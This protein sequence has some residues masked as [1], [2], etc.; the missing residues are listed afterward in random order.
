MNNHQ[1]KLIYKKFL[2]GVCTDEEIDMLFDHFG[3]VNEHDLKQLI[4]QELELNDGDLVCTQDEADQLTN[5]YS[6]IKNITHPDKGFFNTIS[7]YRSFSYQLSIAAVLLV[8]LSIGFWFYKAGKNE[9]N[10]KI[11]AKNITNDVAPGGNKAFL[12]LGNG[13]RISLEQ[14]ASGQIATEDGI[15]ISKTSGG[16]IVYTALAMEP[17]NAQ[18]VSF[19]TIET[20]NGG[21]YQVVL[22]DGTRVWLNAASSLVY[23]T[24]FSGNERVVELKGEG[25]F[26]V[27]KNKKL[28]FKVKSSNQEIEV[29]GTHF[30]VNG[31]LHEEGIK[32]TLLEGSVKVSSKPDNHSKVLLP[33]QQSLVN[34][35][36]IVIKDVEAQDAAAWKDGLFQFNQA[37][38]KSVMREL[39]RWYDVTV[40]YEGN[41]KSQ[42]FGG[43]IQR[44][45]NLSQ[46]LKILEKSQVHFRIE[47][48]EVVVMP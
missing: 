25:Y 11:Q 31:Y 19:N 5:V 43:A 27:A 46:A 38:L 40:R 29:L 20:P 48:K 8:C 30:N 36:S 9:S 4:L 16:Q 23:P 42:R 12:T 34:E 10:N 33:G 1:F 17:E 39:A 15:S 32:T 21:Q 18:A 24:H 2:R 41:I 22:P 35:N 26:E 44:N 37:D 6:R 13:K 14:A 47:G 28:P 45:L 7:A 3:V